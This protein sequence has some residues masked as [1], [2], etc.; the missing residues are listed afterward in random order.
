VKHTRQYLSGADPSGPYHLYHPSF[1]EY[2]A[3]SDDHQVFADEADHDI[4]RYFLGQWQTNRD[5]LDEYGLVHV[6][7]HLEAS[8]DAR[9]LVELLDRSWMIARI[10]RAGG[11][12]GGFLT[13]VDTALRAV[14]ASPQRRLRSK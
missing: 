2:L 7:E 14:F 3:R 9:A 6:A 13:D 12:Y 10:A 8:R 5:A 4:G 11:S 1:V